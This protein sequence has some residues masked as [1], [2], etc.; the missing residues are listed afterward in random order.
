M[1][2]K[3]CENFSIDLNVINND[4]LIKYIVK[5]LIMTIISVKSQFI[6]L[7]KF[8]KKT[9]LFFKCDFLFKAQ[10]FNQLNQKKFF[11]SHIINI[12]IAII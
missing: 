8:Y 11:L 3:S 9:N 2:I 5:C 12:N 4:T 7:F 10:N 6:I 1:F